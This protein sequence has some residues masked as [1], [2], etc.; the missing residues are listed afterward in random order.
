MIITLI[1]VGLGIGAVALVASRGKSKGGDAQRDGAAAPGD[2]FEDFLY[3][4]FTYRVD[5]WPQNRERWRVRIFRNKVWEQSSGRDLEG[6]HLL[7]WVGLKSKALAE[8]WAKQRIDAHK[9]KGD[10]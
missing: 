6:R 10:D 2:E 7:K 8:K 4:G 5:R 3:R 9:E 1:S